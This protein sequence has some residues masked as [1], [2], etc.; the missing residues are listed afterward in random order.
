MG[1]K[2]DREKILEDYFLE[3]FKMDIDKFGETI[4]AQ[5]KKNPGMIEKL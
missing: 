3:C 2:K 5:L 4:Y 1:Q